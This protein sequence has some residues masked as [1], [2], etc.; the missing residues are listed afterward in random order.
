[1]H[2]SVFKFFFDVMDIKELEGKAVLEVGAYNVNGSLRDIIRETNGMSA[3]SY[4][5]TDLREGPM[6]DVIVPAELLD[7]H[8]ADNSFDAIICT[9]MLEHALDWQKAINNMKHLVKVGGF[10]FL[11][12]RSIGFPLHEHPYDYWRFSESDMSKIFSDFNIV[13]ISVDFQVPGIFVKAYKPQEWDTDPSSRVNLE[14][15]QPYKMEQ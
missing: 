10:I 6:V 13:N 14:L 4:I 9:E 3:G 11:T 1:M 2:Y 5:G 8:Y 15:I 7:T 12:T